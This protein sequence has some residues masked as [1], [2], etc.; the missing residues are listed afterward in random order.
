MIVFREPQK[1]SSFL[2]SY[3]QSVKAGSVN[4]NFLFDKLISLVIK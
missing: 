3:F 4:F 2:N 1:S